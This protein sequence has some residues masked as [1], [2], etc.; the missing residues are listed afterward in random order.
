ML[1]NKTKNKKIV[2]RVK[3]GASPFFKFRGLMFSKRIEDTGLIFVFRKEIP[4]SLHMLFVF[5]PIDVILA[6]S[7]KRVVE[8]KKEFRPFTLY[9]SLKPAKYVIELPA[10]ASGGTDVGDTLEF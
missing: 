7:S 3:I 2:S 6:D 1:R 5:F 4:I 10:D 9:D 8:I